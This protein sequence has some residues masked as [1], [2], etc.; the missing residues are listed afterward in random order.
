MFIRGNTDLL[1]LR[2]NSSY[3]SHGGETTNISSIVLNPYYNAETRENDAAL[4]RTESY[5]DR[6][7]VARFPCNENL[8]KGERLSVVGWGYRAQHSG[9]LAEHLRQASL[10]Y[11]DRDCAPFYASQGVNVTSLMFCAGNIK[12]GGGGICTGD[13]GGAAMRN[14][15]VQGIASF[16]IGCGWQSFVSVFTRITPEISDW[17]SVTTGLGCS[18]K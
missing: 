12:I 6:S 2:Y 7:L 9:A 18:D 15:T 11:A 1:Q 13:E 8:H 4:I 3:H 5:L 17:I 10:H 16:N 14:L